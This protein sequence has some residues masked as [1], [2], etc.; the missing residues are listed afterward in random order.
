MIW[1]LTN[2]KFYHDLD[3]EKRA[4]CFGLGYLKFYH[5]LD[6]NFTVRWNFKS[7]K[8]GFISELLEMLLTNRWLG[9]YMSVGFRS[10]CGCLFLV[11]KGWWSGP[12]V[13]STTDAGLLRAVLGGM[14]GPV[15]RRRVGA[16]TM[17]RMS[18]RTRRRQAAAMFSCRF[19]SLNSA[20]HAT[21]S[22]HG[23]VFC[24]LV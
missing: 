5:D 8:K 1:T 20:L 7:C 19:G 9:L 15:G 10:T 14:V 11:N 2:L 4:S 13:Q 6:P 24:F 21:P 3:I 23:S 22:E 18:G 16:W 12:P 17:R